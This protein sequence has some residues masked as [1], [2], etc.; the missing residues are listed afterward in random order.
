MVRGLML[1]RW[2]G[3]AVEVAEGMLTP[4]V[5]DRIIERA[6]QIVAGAEKP[7]VAPSNCRPS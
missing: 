2:N 3:T 5:I 4:D 1:C 7:T 6:V